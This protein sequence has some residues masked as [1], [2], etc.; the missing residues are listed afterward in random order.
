MMA[1]SG[2]R[3]SWDMFARNCDLCWRRFG[4]LSVRLLERLEQPGVLDR[5]DRLVRERLEQGDLPVGE[6]PPLGPIDGQDADGGAFTHER[7][8]H[9]RMKASQVSARLRVL[10][11]MRWPRIVGV[12]GP[13]VQDRPAVD[14][15]SIVRVSRSGEGRIG[16]GNA[17]EQVAVDSVEGRAVSLGQSDRTL[18]DGMKHSTEVGRRG[19]DHAQ[20][21]GCRRLLLQ[22]L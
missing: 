16:A 18:D 5:D 4:E 11:E 9:L 1:F 6:R 19:G 2:V 17:E 21:F 8:R 3:N 13:R 15:L 12:D 20:Q 22:R 14:R 10:R 7:R